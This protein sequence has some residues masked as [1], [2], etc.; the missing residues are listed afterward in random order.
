VSLNKKA[1]LSIQYVFLIF[2]GTI[3]VFVIIGMLTQWSFNTK[4]FTCKLTGDCSAV[5][6]PDDIQV[7]NATNCA[8]FK[9][10]IVKHARL[11]YQKAIA[12]KLPE[13]NSAVCY[14]IMGPSSCL[15]T[16]ADITAALLPYINE[17]N[18]SVSF[19]N[20]D[21]AIISYSFMDRKVRIQ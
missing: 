19:S 3:T 10:E 8:E 6:P 1:D 13:G 9:P 17:F 4:K 2:L 5:T 20:R 11:C 14:N 21:T 15:L 12:G 7:I 16:S 18:S